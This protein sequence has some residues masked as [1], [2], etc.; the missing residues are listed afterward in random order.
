MAML[1]NQRAYQKRGKQKHK[2]PIKKRKQYINDNLLDGGYTGYTI[3]KETH[4]YLICFRHFILISS[5][6]HPTPPA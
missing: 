2:Q 1:N 3:F 5:I 6:M 4:W